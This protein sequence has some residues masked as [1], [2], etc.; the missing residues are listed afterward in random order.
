MH[1][2]YLSDFVGR[3]LRDVQSD[4]QALI[5][6]PLPLPPEV[7]WRLAEV[8]RT[9]YILQTNLEELDKELNASTKI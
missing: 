3:I 4:R 8:T 9:M 7:L 2:A 6:H 1:P 5:D